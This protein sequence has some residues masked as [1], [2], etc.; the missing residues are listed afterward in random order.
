LDPERPWVP[1]RLLPLFGGAR[2]AELTAAQRLRYNHAYARQLVDEFIWTERMMIV[3]PLERVLN[4]VEPGP[5]QAA[6]LNS[7]IA[8]E[9]HHIESFCRLGDLA[10]AAD[11]PAATSMLRPPRTIRGL[12]A[13]AARFPVQL[14]F[15]AT[16]IEAFEQYALKIGQSFHRDDKVD[17]LFRDV[18]VTHA[19]D[20]SRH[21][22]LDP[23][24]GNWLRE[25]SGAR[26]DR[27]N[28]VLLSAFDSAYRSVEWGLDAPL[29][30]LVRSHPEVA[31]SFNALLA[32]VKALRRTTPLPARSE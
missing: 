6:V 7:F 24:I 13:L 32:E 20:E 23:L 1:E 18:F 4:T 19:R 9:R 28:R 12:I 31:S 16:A 15:W 14:S 25:Q 22:R 17:P 30:E 2:H 10:L 29:R 3:R 26:W 5:D 21:C 11:Q 27:V 8:D